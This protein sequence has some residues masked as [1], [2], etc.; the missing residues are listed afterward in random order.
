[1]ASARKFTEVGI[2]KREGAEI[3][4]INPVEKTTRQISLVPSNE[5]DSSGISN[6]PARG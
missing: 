3:P 2:T 1:L 6:G 4:L 5:C